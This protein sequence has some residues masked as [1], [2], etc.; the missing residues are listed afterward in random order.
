[1]KWVGTYIKE[2]ENVGNMAFMAWWVE[3]KEKNDVRRSTDRFNISLPLNSPVSLSVVSL[4]HT[5]KQRH[6]WKWPSHLQ[7]IIFSITQGVD[8]WGPF[9]S[10]SSF[11]LSSC[12]ISLVLYI[13]VTK[14]KL[15]SLFLLIYLFF[16]FFLVFCLHSQLTPNILSTF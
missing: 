6:M 1:M 9:I 4:S 14:L 7:Q 13:V 11:F 3:V 12:E 2:L 15:S 5:H 16:I 10:F 8:P